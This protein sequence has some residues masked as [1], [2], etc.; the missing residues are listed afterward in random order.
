MAD[1]FPLKPSAPVR[2]EI[3]KTYDYT[4]EVGRMLFQCVRSEPK[5][6]RQRRPDPTK[7]G[8]WAWNL[9]GVRRVLY[10]LPDVMESLAGGKV[11]FI[12]E[13]EKDCEALAEADFVATCNPMGAG[14]WLPEHAEALQGAAYVVVIAD[15]D[16]PNAKTGFRPGYSHAET[17]ARALQSR[18]RTVKVIELPDRNGRRVKDAADWFAAGGT[19][20]ELEAIV[21]AAP[22]FVS[23]P[24]PQTIA[25]PEPAAESAEDDEETTPECAAAWPVPSP[26]AFYGLAGD[27]VRLI[28]PHSESDPMAVLSMFLAGFGNIIGPAAHF[29][30]EAKNH[31]ARVW[32]VLVGETAK[33]RKGSAWSNV[34]L[35][36]GRVD[37]HWMRECAKS[38]L[39]S[40]EG[41]I[42]AV[43]DP[44]TKK[45]TKKDGAEEVVMDD[46]V[47]DKRLLTVEEEYS[48]VL[49]V[50]DRQGNTVSDMLRRAWDDGNLATMTK[51]SPAKATG[52]H[53]TVIG[54]ITKAD[55]MK[56]LSQSD[57]LNGFG[58]RFLFVAVKRSKPLP[59][60]GALHTE[61]LAPLVDRLKRAVDFARK[62]TLLVRTDA[63]R[64]LWA[65]VYRELSA[66][67]HGL[68]G[69][70]TGRA[71]AQTMRLAL[72]FAL[73][74]CRSEIDVPHLRAALAV[75]DYCERSAR[76]IFGDS[77]GDKTADRILEELRANRKAGLTR[78]Q[79][80]ELFKG[81][82]A[83]G[84]I[85][86]AFDELARLGLAYSTKEPSPRPGR[87]TTIWR[88]K[89]NVKNVINAESPVAGVI[90]AFSTFNTLG[91]DEK[92][93]ETEASEKEE[94]LLL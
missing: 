48:A 62:S 17:V 51:N 21:E 56:H 11:I 69:A 92:K 94:A 93:I 26:E 42:W 64:E 28:E 46:G 10:R 58:N 9:Q 63:A 24:A 47:A 36:L 23:G 8:G 86:A 72:L 44:S 65:K 13:G 49:K 71:E 4:D 39:S 45:K 87:P 38:G 90:T 22:V 35:I 60:G 61:N 2:S 54:H 14:K 15:K 6:F 16:E 41:L 77:L 53:V 7:P 78:E 50:A 55:L 89:V 3:V 27:V 82:V 68:V 91:S 81:N 25:P 30:A 57:A 34:K 70:L 33:G 32:P 74:D 29:S 76:Y 67:G 59:E 12:A 83:S 20:E 88:A 37:E 43:R 31:P 84:K 66:G 75:W 5:S 79:I 1:L 40:G 73:L 19:A 85:K 18:A 52:A 80:R